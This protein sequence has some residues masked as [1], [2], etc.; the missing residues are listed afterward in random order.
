MVAPTDDGEMV[1]LC[2]VGYQARA[3]SLRQTMCSLCRTDARARR[4]GLLYNT[5]WG[6]AGKRGDTVGD[7]FCADLACRL[8]CVAPS[9]RCSAA[10]RHAIAIGAG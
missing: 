2:I 4:R 9:A 6:E 7:Y 3:S 8:I 10:A 1:G 5:K